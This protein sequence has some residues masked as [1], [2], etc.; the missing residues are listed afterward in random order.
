MKRFLFLLIIFTFHFSLF[1][2]VVSA[3]SL[4]QPPFFKVNGQYS[5]FYAVPITS[6]FFDI[7]QDAAPQNYLVNNPINFEIDPGPLQIPPDVVAKSTFN[8]D[9]GDG[10]KGAGLKNTHTYTKPG[11]YTVEINVSYGDIDAPTLLE[12]ARVNVLPNANYQLPKVKIKVNGKEAKDPLSDIF[13]LKYNSPINFEADVTNSADISKYVWDFNDSQ[14]SNN[15]KVTHT[16]KNN[17]DRAQFFPVLH[18]E[19]KNGFSAD[20]YVQITTDENSSG[21]SQNSSVQK[22]PYLI[23]A[24]AVVVIVTILGFVLMRPKKTK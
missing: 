23:Y 16:Y 20:A 19:D 11:P 18:I 8:W 3:H 5:G 22:P 10:A 12:S 21:G 13:K 9:F 17:P 15:P 1:T 2:S 24:L 7:P 14:T 4:G 6:N